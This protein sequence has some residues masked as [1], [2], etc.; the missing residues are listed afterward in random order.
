[1]AVYDNEQFIHLA[2]RLPLATGYST[3]IKIFVGLGGGSELP[4]ELSV[5]ARESVTV[6]AG[7]FDAFKVVLNIGQTLWISADEHR[8]PVKLEAGGAIIEL[9]E[10]KTGSATASES[11]EDQTCGFSVT[12]PAG[13]MT[14]T[15]EESPQAGRTEVLL[16]DADGI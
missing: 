16:L 7:T 3:K 8:Y 5:P 15:R 9:T 6:P 14:Y 11:Y 4:L 2:R 10:V 12:V 13:W 1:G